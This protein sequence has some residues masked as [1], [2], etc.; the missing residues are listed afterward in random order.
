MIRTR[1]TDPSSQFLFFGVGARSKPSET[2][3]EQMGWARSG[4]DR[5]HP[6]GS[7]ASLSLQRPGLNI[8][9]CQP[10]S[11]S[12]RYNFCILK[13]WYF[14]SWKFDNRQNVPGPW[15]KWRKIMSMYLIGDI[16]HRQQ[17]DSICS[18]PRSPGNSVLMVCAFWSSSS[19]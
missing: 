8:W 1:V 6:P 7:W 2:Q 19:N 4:Q 11:P 16:S 3:D 18:S 14:S 10:G 5:I 13:P 17:N 15:D 9:C 12:E